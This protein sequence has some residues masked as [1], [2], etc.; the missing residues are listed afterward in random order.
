M[1]KW[2]Y[3]AITRVRHFSPLR[4]NDGFHCATEWRF[5]TTDVKFR[6]IFP[7]GWEDLLEK[8]GDI[9]WEL[10]AVSPRSSHLGRYIEEDGD[11]YE[12]AGFT[13]QEEWIFKRPK[14]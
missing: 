11:S 9:G 12:V 7:E 5:A 6:R 4:G 14:E 8:I 10:V 13:D 3:A 2:E 1:Q